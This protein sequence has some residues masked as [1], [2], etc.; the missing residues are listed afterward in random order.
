MATVS[1]GT[2]AAGQPS[3][4]SKLIP[5]TTTSTA[6]LEYFKDG[7]KLLDEGHLGEAAQ[8]PA[9]AIKSHRMELCARSISN[10]LL[11]GLDDYFS[12]R[13]HKSERI[14]FAASALAPKWRLKTPKRQNTLRHLVKFGED[15]F[16]A[17]GLI[18][19]L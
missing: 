4:T 18:K 16:F 14:L 17:D 19:I 5:I 10:E 7:V 13:C 11:N 3:K 2:A 9:E 12:L 8:K 15:D 6:A 1:A